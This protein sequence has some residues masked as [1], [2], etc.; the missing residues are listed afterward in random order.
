MTLASVDNDDFGSV[1]PCGRRSFNCRRGQAP[2]LP[3]SFRKFADYRLKPIG[4]SPAN[5]TAVDLS[6]KL[7]SKKAEVQ[8][9]G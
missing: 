1:V 4:M 9:D 2:T 3:L 7:K 6:D 8:K 5:L